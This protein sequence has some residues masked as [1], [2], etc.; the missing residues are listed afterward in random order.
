MDSVSAWRLRTY[1]IPWNSRPVPPVYQVL[2]PYLPFPLFFFS[3]VQ[4]G[5]DSQQILLLVASAEL[6]LC[7]GDQASCGL[8]MAALLRLAE[9]TRGRTSEHHTYAK[10]LLPTCCFHDLPPRLSWDGTW[11][12]YSRALSEW[13]PGMLGEGFVDSCGPS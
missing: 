7:A 13:S 6:V 12:W 2:H 9:H 8:L 4:S 1:C 5:E 11:E 3:P 10:V